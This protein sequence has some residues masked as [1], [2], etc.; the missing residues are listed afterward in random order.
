MEDYRT[1]AYM[2]NTKPVSSEYDKI[3]GAPIN[4]EYSALIYSKIKE[5]EKVHKGG[6]YSQKGIY[7][8]E[9]TTENGSTESFAKKEIVKPNEIKQ[10]LLFL[11]PLRILSNHLN[12]QDQ[13]VTEEFTAK[14]I[15]KYRILKSV[16]APTFKDVFIY[17]GQSI[18]TTLIHSKNEIIAANNCFGMG[19]PICGID[20]K[21]INVK[22]YKNSLQIK[23]FNEFVQGIFKKIKELN[24]KGCSLGA[25]SL[26]FTMPRNI[27]ENKRIIDGEWFI[28]D[29][30]NF[31]YT[32]GATTAL[33]NGFVQDIIKFVK[34]FVQKEHQ[35]EY[36]GTI[37]REWL[38]SEKNSL[39][40]V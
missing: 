30:D 36:L 40:K 38:K 6:F 32:P 3:L 37:K 8:L 35:Q 22:Q 2:K 28:G 23:N 39:E 15:E 9:I 14:L 1:E 10:M 26:F 34:Y 25:D 12:E 11:F 20:R 7:S 18:I 21:K 13:S 17:K 29:P 31:Y 27:T 19:L 16:D 5:I 4:E 33:D 24:S